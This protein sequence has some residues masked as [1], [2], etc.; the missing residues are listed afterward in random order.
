M[1]LDGFKTLDIGIV[2]P[3]EFNERMKLLLVQAQ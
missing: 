1:S 2:S 3:N